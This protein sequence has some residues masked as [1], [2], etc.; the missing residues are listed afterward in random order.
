MIHDK[1]VGNSHE[2]TLAV[3]A[4]ER[5]FYRVVERDDDGCGVMLDVD[6]DRLRAGMREVVRL[7]QHEL[8]QWQRLSDDLL[9]RM[10][11]CWSTS[12]CCPEPDI[13][14]CGGVFLEILE[15]QGDFIVFDEETRRRTRQLCRRAL[16]H[17]DGTIVVRRHRRINSRRSGERD[18]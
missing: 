3:E 4:A 2:L 15:L 5:W 17:L 10:V 14:G 6:D 11:K 1:S 9:L 7:I 12:R 8:Q 18:Q 16:S 13:L